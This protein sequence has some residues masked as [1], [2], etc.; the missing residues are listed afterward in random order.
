MRF[1]RFLVFFIGAACMLASCKTKVENGYVAYI[2][3]RECINL[4]DGNT[5]MLSNPEFNKK[6]RDNNVTI[7]FPDMREVEKKKTIKDYSVEGMN[8]IFSDKEMEYY[9]KLSGTD[10]SAMLKI[11]S[12][13]VKEVIKLFDLK[14]WEYEFNLE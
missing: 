6:L 3:A 2:N 11:K 14:Y 7:V 8:V 13:E 1:L 4:T 9:K 5:Y 12:G 10:Y